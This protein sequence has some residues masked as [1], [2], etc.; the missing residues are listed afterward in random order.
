M[1]DSTKR[2]RAARSASFPGTS[3]ATARRGAWLALAV[4][5]GLGAF[6]TERAAAE[7]PPAGGMSAASQK[8]GS[9]PG[10]KL[11][12]LTEAPK[13]LVVFDRASGGRPIARLTG[14]GVRMIV[15][16]LPAQPG[17]ALSAVSVDPDGFR[18]D[19]YADT[20][21]LQ[22]FAQ[23]RLEVV[24]GHV[25][26]TSAQPLT[27]LASRAGEIQVQAQVMTSIQQTFTTWAPCSALALEPPA[28]STEPS[29]LDEHPSDSRLYIT[30]PESL[31]LFPEP[32]KT[33]G[34]P[35]VTI[36]RSGWSDGI[37]LRGD[38]QKNGLVHVVYDAELFIDAWAKKTD[39]KSV[40][41]GELVDQLAPPRKVKTSQIKLSS[42]PVVLKA[43]T[44]L[45]LR[46]AAQKD[47]MPVGSV[48]P[49]TELYLVDRVAEWGRVL[50]KSLVLTAP[51]GE[52]YWVL[53]ADLDSSTEK[54]GS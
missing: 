11:A 41:K 44:K 37:V 35:V 16:D 8:P 43:K 24:P 20:S 12:G 9:G 40:P 13:N 19:G 6:S 26:V 5:I 28:P 29:D 33:N 52:P 39:L 27:Q 54:A 42:T 18:I 21:K 22:T 17:T 3:A 47:A 30:R 23:K 10:C 38:R 46:L 4:S 7:E 1:A 50:P 14:G 2:S 51:E 49:G 45:D 34:A 15:S 48:Q 36:T 31:D 25:W 53:A 32:G